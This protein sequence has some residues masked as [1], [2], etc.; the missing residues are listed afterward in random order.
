MNIQF[1]ATYYDSSSED[2]VL[3][4]GLADSLDDPKHFLILQRT[5]EVYEQ[6]VELGQDTYYVEIGEP[7]MAGYGGVDDVLIAADKLV[8]NFSNATPWCNT[9]KTIGIEITPQLGSI[10]DIE[11]SLREIFIETSTTITRS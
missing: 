6:D 7:G 3:T 8:F 1:S 4:F 10:D 9:I 2:D 5:E 11:S